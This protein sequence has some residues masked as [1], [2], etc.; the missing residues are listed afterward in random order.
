[1]FA[2][3]L[4]L[5]LALAGA[6]EPTGPPPA[7]PTALSLRLDNDI[8]VGTDKDYSSGVFLA[9]SRD[10]RGPLGGVWGWFGAAPERLVSSYE[11]GHVIM[12]PA[13]ILEPLPDPKDR[14]YAGVLFGALGTQA[15]DGDRLNGLELL[16]GVVGP[17]SLAGPI[18]RVIHTVTLSDQAQGWDSQLRDE[19]VL[20][21]FVEHRRRQLLRETPGGWNVQALPRVGAGVGNL[22]VQAEAEAYVRVGR[23]LP[24]DFGSSQSGGFGHLPLPP[25]R[26]QGGTPGESGLYLFAGAGV[27][28]VARNLTLDGNTFADGPRVEK[29]GVVPSGEVG[30]SLWKRHVAATVSFVAR[31]REFAAQWRPSRYGSATLTYSF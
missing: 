8:V 6:S 1:M 3:A 27:S 5:A 17:A 21:V 7:P 2:A 19:L 18:Q 24:D 23:H 20:N 9:L 25:R 10:G 12:T 4:L 13:N 29:R 22:L 11:L 16:V 30:V 14:P 31:G 26:R 28:F 15:I